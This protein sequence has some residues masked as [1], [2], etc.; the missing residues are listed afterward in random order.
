MTE[1][2][3]V[4]E[5]QAQMKVI[6]GS[7]LVYEVLPHHGHI[8]RPISTIRYRAYLEDGPL[9]AQLRS[10]GGDF[11]LY[12]FELSPG[13]EPCREEL[14]K[15]AVTIRKFNTQFELFERTLKSV[16]LD[17]PPTPPPSDRL[18]PFCRYG[19]D[20]FPYFSVISIPKLHL[21]LRKKIKEWAVPEVCNRYR[22]FFV[23]K[24]NDEMARRH[25]TSY[26]AT[27][28]TR[29]QVTQGLCVEIYGYTQRG[30]PLDGHVYYLS[31]EELRVAGVIPSEMS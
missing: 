21:Y 6:F 2:I 16:Q 10:W 5:L 31:Y 7:S 1:L 11:E 15:L 19:S 8:K 28:L 18:A 17:C 23:P 3:T 13:T 22:L 12:K 26:L 25:L 9:K 27:P 30:S 29:E 4:P 24:Y 14:G 20:I